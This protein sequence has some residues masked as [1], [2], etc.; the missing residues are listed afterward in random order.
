MWSLL[1]ILILLVNFDFFR[2][3][4]FWDFETLFRFALS[5]IGLLYIIFN[6]KKIN[7]QIKKWVIIFYS[8]AF[9]LI[10]PSSLNL[11]QSVKDTVIANYALFSV[12]SSLVLYILF[13]SKQIKFDV[14]KIFLLLI[15]LDF[16][17]LLLL[18]ITDTTL[19]YTSIFTGSS[20]ESPTYSFCNSFIIFGVLYYFI[21]YIQKR[22]LFHLILSM[23]LFFI[24]FIFKLQRMQ[25]IFTIIV[26]LAFIVIISKKL[27][28]GLILKISIIFIIFQF[29][30]FLLPG[31]FLDDNLIKLSDAFNLF[32]PKAKISDVSTLA[33]VGQ[34]DYALEN[35]AK[36][37]LLGNGIVRSS[38][39]KKVYGNLYFIYVDIGLIGLIYIGG[40]FGL[41][42]Y[43]YQ[44]FDS[45]K[46]IKFKQILNNS[47]FDNAVILYLLFI[48]FS[49]FMTGLTFNTPYHF[50]II[51]IILN[52][53]QQTF[54]KNN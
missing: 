16:S 37:P 43:L 6:L 24:P 3:T 5:I 53:K 29:E 30:L 40:I 50:L 32:N 20:I 12:S 51:L 27:R 49:S 38:N 11:N 34:I 42:L 18:N 33:R 35:I 41:L 44:V 36:N 22:N 25:F 31:D 39:A 26:C 52:R 8:F 46:K 13:Q 47:V 45:I 10:V 7:P 19:I 2:A 54:I 48:V 28:A 1:V 23:V 17:V 15:W 4:L 14:E 9:Y 21:S